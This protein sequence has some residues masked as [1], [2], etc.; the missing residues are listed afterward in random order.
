[1]SRGL[2]LRC[3]APDCVE[4][5]LIGAALYGVS[6]NTETDALNVPL[7]VL[8][9][10]GLMGFGWLAEAPFVEGRHGALHYRHN[11][12]YLFGSIVLRESAQSVAEGVSAFQQISQQAYVAVFEVLEKTGFTQLLRCWNY[13]PRINVDGGGLERYRQFNIGRQEAFIAAGQAW[14]EGSPSACA[15]GCAE[16]D[17]IVYFLAGKQAALLIENPRQVSAYR[18]PQQYGP[19]APTFSRASL[20]R[21]PTEEA[22]FISGTASIVGHES[23]HW[24]D[25][26]AQTRETLNNLDAVVAQA[27]LQARLG[28]FATRNLCLKVYV[29]H[30]S[31]QAA[32]AEELAAR[33]GPDLNVTYLLADI[34]RIELLVEVEAFGFLDGLAS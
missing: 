30:A 15:L 5:R 9:Q 19:R 6:P 7:P 29:R 1:M 4:P 20:L 13:L 16:G 22:L 26:R 28:Q 24:G 31:D 17:L 23:V 27:N 21:L 10:G 11:D 18:Y 14:L 32:V 33:L 25:V 34:C 3:I 12:D 2:D 8:P